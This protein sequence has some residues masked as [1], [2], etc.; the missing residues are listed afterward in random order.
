MEGVQ[1][2]IAEIPPTPEVESDFSDLEEELVQSYIKKFHDNIR[3]SLSLIMKGLRTPFNSLK[4]TLTRSVDNIRD[5]RGSERAAPFDQIVL[6][7]ER[8]VQSWKEAAQADLSPL[9]TA[10]IE[11]LEAER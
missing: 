8:D 5:I 4:M 10:E 1:T 3:T 9:I 2:S 7:F 11:R 6:D